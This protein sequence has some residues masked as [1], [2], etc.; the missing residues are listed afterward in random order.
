MLKIIFLSYFQLL[1]LTFHS[2]CLNTRNYA[3]MAITN[4]I[5]AG[6]YCTMFRTLMQNVDDPWTI[7]AYATGTTFGGLSGV[8]LH[9][10]FLKEKS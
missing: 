7:V 6:L 2:R 3:G 1:L 9:H 8:W 4:I 10:R 5:V